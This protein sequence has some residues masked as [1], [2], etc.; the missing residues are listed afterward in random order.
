MDVAIKPSVIQGIVEAPASK[1]AAHRALICAA[2]SDRPTTV[3][4]QKAGEDVHATA[5]CLNALCASVVRQGDAFTVTPGGAGKSRVLNCGESGSTLRFLLPVAFALGGAAFAGCGR[6]PERPIGELKGQLEAHGAVFSADRLPFS[7]RGSD[8]GGDFLLPGSVSSQYVTG[9][10]LAAPLLRREVAIKIEGALESRPYVDMTLETMRAFG[11]IAEET[12]DGFLIPGG[13]AYHSPGE[14]RV[15]GDWSG[16]AFLLALGA[17]CGEAAVT[18]LHL[19]STQGDKRIFSLLTRMGAEMSADASRVVARKRP[20]RAIDEDVSDIPDLV[21]VLCALLMHAQ[22]V[23]HL[24]NAGRLRLKESDRLKT[25][26][27]FV[28]ALGGRAWIENDGL[29]IPGVGGALGGRADGAGDHRIVMAAAVAGS[30]CK[31]TTTIIGAQAADKSYPGFL[32]DFATL[33]G[34]AHGIDIRA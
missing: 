29:V 27:A 32:T 1:S 26:A 24:T 31:G 7:V 13:Q 23:S 21:P 28:N 14:V 25:S 20:L 34:N 19:N 16:A 18:G 5:Q 17:L 3:Y 2:L 11:V 15:E 12:K 9:L 10:L 8:A 33:G 4:I 22:G 6:L 30:A